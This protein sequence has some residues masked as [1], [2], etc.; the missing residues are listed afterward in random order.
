MVKPMRTETGLVDPI[1]KIQIP[2]NRVAGSRASF[3]CVS[4]EPTGIGL[5]EE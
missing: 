3:D 5:N 4:D 1:R 2:A